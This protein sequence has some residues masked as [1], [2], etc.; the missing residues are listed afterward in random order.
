ME[1]VS[2]TKN[3]LKNSTIGLSMKVFNLI[4]A[5]VVRTI[6][7]NLL[8]KEY[9][10]ING[11][12]SDILMLLSFAELG[13]GSAILYSMYKPIAE[14]DF[15]KINALIKLYQ[16]CY[17]II[18]CIVIL[19]GGVLTPFIP[20]LING[21]IG[22]PVNIYIVFMLYVIQTSSSY[23][24]SSRQSFLIASQKQYIVD[25]TLQMIKLLKEICLAIVLLLTHNFYI[26]L[27]VGIVFEFFA[28]LIFYLYIGR[29]NQFLKEKTIKPLSK[30]EKKSIF[31]NVLSIF[32]YKLGAV[33][34]AGT[35]NIII[36]S[37]IGLAEV[38]VLSN[39]QM[40]SSSVTTLV[41][42]VCNS[43]IS[44]IGNL[45]IN[46]DIDKQE[47]VFNT[48]LLL[49]FWSGS[50]LSIGMTLFFNPIFTLVWGNEYTFSIW[51]VLAIALNF[52]VG[53][54]QFAGYS[55][56]ITKGYFKNAGW[57]PLANAIINILLSILLVKPWG[58]FG[59]LIA[60]P[61]SRIFTVTIA[62]PYF[63]Y[64][65]CF[66]KS[67]FIFYF[68]YLLYFMLFAATLSLSYFI[69]SLIPGGTF[70]LEILKMIVCTIL[71]NTLYLIIF[72]RSK[73]FKFLLEKLG[74]LFKKKFK[75]KKKESKK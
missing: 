58:V 60:T 66:K 65:N 35:D 3:V 61:I 28:N 67:P 39:Y 69:N 13:I 27:I 50:F 71:V 47:K 16:K 20:Y 2:R 70:V 75:H 1:E 9:L 14:N 15:P 56:R 5:F 23:F 26:Y 54:T 57:I 62:D 18:G 64:K 63:T 55:F 31:I 51:V 6:F 10:G 59:V 45:N 34:L 12:F 24:F 44:S 33:I 30:E 19:V 32:V 25:V 7:I 22:V 36:S 11:L 37:F 38:G 74:S 46:N 52:Y 42:S 49:S 17:V 4:L 72:W 73:S 8:G 41:N 68:K 40:I 48:L 21:E 43:T 29:K 53:V